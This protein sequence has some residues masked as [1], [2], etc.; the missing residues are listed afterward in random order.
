M[1]HSQWRKSA[2]AAIS[3]ATAHLP[4]E[5][6]LAER[7]RALRGEGEAFH[8]GTS[9]GRKVW[10]QECRKY[11]ELH[12]QPKRKPEQHP[13]FADDITFPFRQGAQA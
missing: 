4:P 10:G 8:G 12:G 9:W 5:A 1:T 2:Q 13:R 3:R 6:T 11:Y 7:K